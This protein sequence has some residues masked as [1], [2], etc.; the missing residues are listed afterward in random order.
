MELYKVTITPTSS[1]ATSLKGDTLFGQ[2]CWGIYYTI[3]K[4]ELDDLLE[5]YKTSNT[6]DN[7]PFLVVSDGFP[8]GYLP[9]PKMPSLQLNEDINEHK[10]NRKKLWLTLDELK[11]GIYS[12]ARENDKINNMDTFDIHIH[13]ALNYQT[14]HTGE[15]FDPYAL[16]EMHFSPRDIYFLL[17]EKQLTFEKFKQAFDMVAQTG[18]GKKTTI[19]KGRFSYGEFKK[20][21]INHQGR[22]FMTLSP[23]APQNQA[24]K[25]LYYEPFTRFGKFGAER[26]TIN[27]FKK[28]LLLADTASVV[29]FEEPKSFQY[30]GQA[31]DKLSDRH[32]DTVHQGYAIVV[33]IKELRL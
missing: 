25:Q 2:I 12:N 23:F 21:T 20:I 6:T 17:D 28:P 11:D 9:K 7:P 18:Y 4:K 29:A 27:A 32:T 19:G 3:G 10:T 5:A 31:I 1:F 16:K 33:P 15:G 24:Y 8:T 14:F 26:A 22:A 13:N 30:L